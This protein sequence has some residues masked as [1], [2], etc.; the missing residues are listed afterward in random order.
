MTL[1]CRGPHGKVRRVQWWRGDRP[2]ARYRPPAPSEPIFSDRPIAS[3][4]YVK[5]SGDGHWL[6]CNDVTGLSRRMGVSMRAH[7]PQ[8][9]TARRAD[10]ASLGPL[11]PGVPSSRQPRQRSIFLTLPC[12]PFHFQSDWIISFRVPASRFP[13]R[14][15]MCRL[16]VGLHNRC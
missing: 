12:R 11:I 6:R 9:S 15:E 2:V 7:L 10:E 1:D 3:H 14:R 8:A 5:A 13:H 16:S 4:T